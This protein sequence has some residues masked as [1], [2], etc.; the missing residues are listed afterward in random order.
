MQ[1]DSR[2]LKMAR[3][4]SRMKLFMLKKLPLALLV[5]LK[6]IEINSEKAVVSIPYKFLNKN[7]FQSIYFAALSMAAELSTGALAMAAISER[8]VPISMLVFGMEARFL[9][10]AQTKILFTCQQGYEIRQAIDKCLESG[11]GETVRVLSKGIDKSGTEVAEFYFTWT[12]K[13][14]SISP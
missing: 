10:K 11:A 9:K 7:P 14:K 13:P 1:K 4:N 6:I 5:G 3:N 8:N 12:F 2:F